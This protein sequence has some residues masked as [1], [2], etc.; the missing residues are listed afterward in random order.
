VKLLC[1]YGG[2][3]RDYQAAVK[4]YHGISMEELAKV[5]TGF[6]FSCSFRKLQVEVFSY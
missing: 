5:V 2:A 6:A 4:G 3:T 1:A